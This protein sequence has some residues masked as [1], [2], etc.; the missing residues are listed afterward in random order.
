MTNWW[1]VTH[2][3]ENQEGLFIDRQWT[4]SESGNHIESRNPAAPEEVVA[5][6]PAATSDEASAAVEV[7]VSA[8]EPWASRSAHD[9]GD[10]LREVAHR[11]DDYRDDVARLMV[12]EMGKDIGSAR[13]EVQRTVD[14]L[15]TIRR[16]LGTPVA[17][18]RRA[19][20]RTR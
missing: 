13:G 7:A 9:H 15:G 19:P 11:L 18:L 5:T 3:M 14:L 16:W 20:T 8:Q 4:N 2:T 10:V 12:H 6:Y 17:P 1:L